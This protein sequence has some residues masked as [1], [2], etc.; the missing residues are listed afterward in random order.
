MRVD[1]PYR[2]PGF[3]LLELLVVITI[4]LIVSAV[5][6]PTV[7]PALAHREVSEAAR[8]LQGALIGARDQAIHTNQPS[9]VRFLP[10]PSFNGIGPEFLIDGTLNPNG[11][12]MDPNQVLAANRIIPLDPAPEYSE[13]MVSVPSRS[14]LVSLQ[15]NGF[16]V[17]YPLANGGG[18]Y[19]LYGSIAGPGAPN[20]LMVHEALFDTSGAVPVPNP[21]TSWFWN[22][23]VGDK[24]QINQAGPWYTV[25]GPMVW[26]PAGVSSGAGGMT[27]PPNPE[28][29]VNIG[30]PGTKSPLIQ[31][32]A[33]GPLAA[34]FLFLVNSQD[35]NNNGW[36]DEG[37][38][39]VDNNGNGLI[40]EIVE[41]E[42]EAWLGS[43]SAGGTTSQPYTI[44]R[45]PAP[46]T[47]ARAVALPTS[48][49]VDL[50]GWGLN[51]P[52]RSRVPGPALN[53][54]TGQ[55]DIMIN[56]DGTVVPT[57]VYSSP[58]SFTM[59]SAFTHLWLAERSDLMAPSPSRAA[60]PH[61]PVP[62]G[63]APTMFPG[64]EQIKGEYALVTIFN[65]TG[66]IIVN[67][68]MRFDNPLNP[69]NTTYGYDP[70]LP[71]LPS[72]QGVNGGP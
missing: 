49:V 66:E 13:G 28:M 2:R 5:A 30:A 72:R 34:E 35:D 57:T 47:N 15:A 3:T 23:R 58:S 45:R 54:F 26:P 24:I 52:E 69:I 65:R 9:G 8:L 1:F 32:T 43:L 41:W 64:D 18:N 56:P 27:V 19:P 48:V 59:A 71:F 60:P 62:Y 31:A 17:A 46:S 10:D 20:V 25:V 44:R 50:T 11:G 51:F 22:V 21:P 4:I 42:P 6:L 33:A 53:R 61:L 7:L 70:N 68:N 37:W 12:V 55:L 67:S 36:V 63:L 40:D 38:D 29:F 16:Q 14:D 39:G